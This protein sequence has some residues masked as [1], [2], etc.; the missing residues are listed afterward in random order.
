M[1]VDPKVLSGNYAEILQVHEENVEDIIFHN[2]DFGNM[3]VEIP[4]EIKALRFKPQFD[5][6]GGPQR[7]GSLFRG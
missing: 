5:L 4:S 7:G 2:G 6:S 3:N 1:R